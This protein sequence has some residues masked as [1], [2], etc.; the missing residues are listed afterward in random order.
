VGTR[1]GKVYRITNA[2]KEANAI[3]EEITS[4]LFPKNGWISCIEYDD[5]NGILLVSFSN[6]EVVSIFASFDDGLTWQAVAGNLEENPDGSGSGPSVR[7]IESVLIDDKVYYFA[8]TD[9]GLFSTDKLN[10][11]KTIWL[12]EG[13]NTIG[14]VICEMIDAY[15]NNKIVVAT[16]GNGV[17]VSDLSKV[18]V[19]NIDDTD[20]Q[21][22]PNPTNNY[23]NLTL[24]QLTNTNYIVS[25]YTYSGDLKFIKQYNLNMIKNN[26]IQIDISHLESGLYILTLKT[27]DMI[28][29]TKLIKN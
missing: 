27:N 13:K 12:Q 5:E 19:S 9:A 2:N 14:N 16:Q 15:D 28:K 3:R 24:S 21:I 6:Y 22:Y 4:N 7:W 23:V 18:S 20:I 8:A 10:G 26:N 25:I 17:W 29:I 11:E 1:F